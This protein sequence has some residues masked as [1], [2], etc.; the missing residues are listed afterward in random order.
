MKKHN[1]QIAAAGYLKTKSLKSVMY[2]KR[3]NEE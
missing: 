3:S 2:N 1:R